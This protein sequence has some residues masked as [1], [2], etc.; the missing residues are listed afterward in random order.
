MHL[1]T[2]PIHLLK[3]KYQVI[4]NQK[5]HEIY[6]LEI[7]PIS[8]YYVIDED[9]TDIQPPKTFLIIVNMNKR[10]CPILSRQNPTPFIG[11]RQLLLL[12]I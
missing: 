12:R 4:N 5:T 6:V 10:L 9:Y 1:C 2:S 3:W 7:S 11:I 8:R